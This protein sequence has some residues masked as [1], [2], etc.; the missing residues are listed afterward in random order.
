MKTL[1]LLLVIATLTAVLYGCSP[2]YGCPA[3]ARN[4][5][6]EN[7]ENIKHPPK[8]SSSLSKF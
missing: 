7:A 4:T 6:A 5:G 3:N 8:F 1:R 2:K